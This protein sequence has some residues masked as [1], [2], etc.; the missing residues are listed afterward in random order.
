MW[1]RSDGGNGGGRWNFFLQ[2]R[3]SLIP[4]G[5]VLF[6]YI[7]PGQP[8]KISTRR[9]R[10]TKT[11]QRETSTC[12]RSMCWRPIFTPSQTRP[13]SGIPSGKCH[14][15]RVR[16]SIN[17]LRR[18][19]LETRNIKLEEV[20]LTA[21]AW[22]AA[23]GQLR[24]MA[25]ADRV[26]VKP[27]DTTTRTTTDVNAEQ[28]HAARREQTGPAGACFNC[29]EEGH[30]ARDEECPARGQ[31][32]SRCGRRGHLEVP[33]RQPKQRP[34]ETVSRARRTQVNFVKEDG[35]IDDYAF[36]TSIRRHRCRRTHS[37]SSSSRR[38]EDIYYED[39]Q[40]LEDIVRTQEEGRF[41]R[42]RRTSRIWRKEDIMKTRR[43]R[44][45]EGF[46][47]EVHVGGQQQAGRRIMKQ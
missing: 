33:C 14:N 44:R 21:R 15:R 31:K 27:E 5:G 28:V 35:G 23:E 30:Y 10:A 2:A 26:T 24:E 19:F 13:L 9:S 46:T 43:S 1:S 18:K 20:L 16:L 40:K 6:F 39:K 42:S 41:C 45:K 32:C 22:E 29:G 12:G 25:M 34:K 37:S 36:L 47:E 7:M 4:V 8:F 3:T 11:E 38:K 17:R